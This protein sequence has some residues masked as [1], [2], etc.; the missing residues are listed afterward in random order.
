ME[1]KKMTATPSQT[2]GLDGHGLVIRPLR[3]DDLTA[4]KRLAQLDSSPLP[5]GDLLGALVEG[6]LL[7]AISL[8]SGESIADP[9]SRTAEL[10]ALLE[11]RAA[12]LRRRVN[13]RRRLRRKLPR[14]KPQAAL[15]GSPPGAERWLMARRWRPL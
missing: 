14:P 6:R 5:E 15:A 8:A 3:G 9:F 13:G 10:R 1:V 7:A 4:A 2:P 12:Q 11:L